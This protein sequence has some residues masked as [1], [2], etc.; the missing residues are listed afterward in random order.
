M[1]L[2]YLVWVLAS[3]TM[4]QDATT[5]TTLDEL[6]KTYEPATA[7]SAVTQ[8]WSD[9]KMAAAPSIVDPGSNSYSIVIPPPNVTAALHLGHALNNTLQDVLVR[10]HRMLG[11]ATLW[12]PG[13]DHAG[14][15]TQ[16]V[17]EKRLLTQDIKRLDMGRDAFIA[18]T[19][20]WKDEYEAI[21]IEQ[22]LAMGASCDWD[23]TRFTMDEMCAT[24]VRHAF[25][26]LFQDGLIYRGKRLVN[27]DPAT[28]TALSDDEVEMEEVAGHMWY[29]KY[30]LEDGSG[31]VTV[32]T[33][34]PETMLGDTAVGIN[35]NDPRAAELSGKHVRLPIVD[36]LIPIVEDDYVVMADPESDEVKAQ[37]A[38][39]FLKVTPAHDAND[40]DIGLRH[41]LDVINVLGPDGAIS[42]EYGW[43]D[44]S[45][46]AQ[47]FVGM[48]REDARA[49]IV[50]WFDGHDLLAEIRDYTHS[51]GHSYRSHVPIEPWLSDQWFVAVTDDR[52]RGAA[53]RAQSAN[54]TSDLPEDVKPRSE[55]PG[56]GELN[57]FP[58]RYAKTY[59]QWHE[60]IR[61]W[62]ISR[63]LWWGHQIPV[64]TRTI[65][66]SEASAGV[67]ATLEGAAVDEPRTVESRWVDAGAAHQVRKVTES[68]LEEAVCVP[69]DATLGRLQRSDASHD[70]NGLVEALEAEGF[71]RDPDV[72]DTWFSSGLWPMSTMGWPWP[73]DYPET[74]GLLSSYNPTSVLMTA[75][76]IITL[77]VSRMTMFNRYFMD[78]DVPFTD[79]FIH[80]MIQDGHGQKMSKSLGNGVDPRDIIH[81]HGADAMRFTLVQMTTDTQDVRMPVDMVCPYTGES[82]GPEFITTAAGHVVAAPIQKSPSDPDKEMVSAYGVAVGEVEA[83]SEA[84]LA[85]N[86]SAKFD[87]GRNFANKVWNATRFALGRID[88]KI[89]LD[90]PINLDKAAFADRWIVARLSQ[91]LSVMDKALSEYQFNLYADTLYDFIWRDVC[92]RYLEAVKPTIDGNPEQQAV[93]GAVLD[94]VLRVL[95]PACP[96][97]TETL[98]PSVSSVRLGDIHGV[99][100]PPSDLVATAAWPTVNETAVDL[101]VIET[102]DRADNLIGAIRKVRSERNVKPKQMVVLHAPPRVQ[103]LIAA[104]G[105]AIETLAG[106]SEVLGEADERPPGASAIAFE[107]AEVLISGLV[108]ELDLDA[109]QTRL[110]KIIEA[111]ASQIEN[112]EKRLANPGYVNNAK[113]ELVEETRQQLAAAKQDMAAAQSA[114]SALN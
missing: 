67:A 5:Q 33:T 36:R 12:M 102:F 87:Q 13:T 55:A 75:R 57:F 23:R 77:W 50:S 11:D 114:L 3:M 2:H 10:Y 4:T 27:W 19:Q 65:A 30:P 96:F 42:S 44:V 90:A 106:V 88:S 113:P 21:I 35:P 22:L 89:P 70:E 43:D 25:F 84:P 72:L 38:S 101:G 48:S 109:E 41:D 107:G 105:G 46:E 94:A 112:F 1:A 71:S 91:T 103:E 82:F 108:D 79:V 83:T 59:Q 9:A 17:V 49:A 110:E 62:C 63:Q 100:L 68:E 32:A 51:V 6:P 97:I 52:L 28:R 34:R 29:L 31:H 98:W 16:T 45:E 78:G 60:G 26:K 111:K 73:E 20:E 56:D 8:R 14:I 99:Q 95:H 104:S 37:Y 40:W 76:E 7:E 80:A 47:Q 74:V 66:L 58:P 61:D 54:Q 53:L 85:R 93:L 69:P 15:A 24:A 81:S 64:W 39:G 86:T 92:D 18:K